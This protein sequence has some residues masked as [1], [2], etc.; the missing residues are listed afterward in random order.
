ML[1]QG[2]KIFKNKK[3]KQKILMEQ[4]ALYLKLITTHLSCGKPKE[5]L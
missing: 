5:I 3:I 1:R 4:D 2:I